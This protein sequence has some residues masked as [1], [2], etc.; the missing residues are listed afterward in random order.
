ML[1]L[2]YEAEDRPLLTTVPV[3]ISDLWILPRT[4]KHATGIFFTPPSVGPSSSN[5]SSSTKKSRPLLRSGFWQR[6]RD[7]NPRER[8]QSPVCYR[9]TNPLCVRHGYYYNDERQNVKSYFP[10]LGHFS[11]AYHR[12]SPFCRIIP[13][14][15][16]FPSKLLFSNT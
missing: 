16:A 11:P 15:K 2:F 5:P 8:S 6:M 3:A 4:K 14:E 9:Y 13:K 10:V 12:I 7:S 1:P